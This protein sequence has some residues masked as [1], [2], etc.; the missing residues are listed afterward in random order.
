MEGD[1]A[2]EYVGQNAEVEGI[3]GTFAYR[4]FIPYVIKRLLELGSGI[5]V[6]MIVYSGIMFISAGGNEDQRTK[7]MKNIGFAIMGLLFMILS[8]AIVSIVESL[9]LG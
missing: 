7:Q 5:A 9:P 6:L 2:T 3:R 8:R 1:K 4:T